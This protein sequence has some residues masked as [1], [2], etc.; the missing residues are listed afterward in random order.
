MPAAGGSWHESAYVRWFR[1]IALVRAW[2]THM[3]EL[4]ER[5]EAHSAWVKKPPEKAAF[6]ILVRVKGLEPPWGEP[7]T[8]LNRTRLPIPPHPRGS[9]NERE[10]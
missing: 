1:G 5:P 3:V 9:Q 2:T 6:R 7:H 10:R 8:D 4:R